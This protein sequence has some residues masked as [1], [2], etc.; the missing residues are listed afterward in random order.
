MATNQI[1]DFGKSKLKYIRIQLITTKFACD[2]GCLPNKE[3]KKVAWSK[4]GESQQ[5]YGINHLQGQ[6]DWRGF[7][8][9]VVAGANCQVIS[10]FLGLRELESKQ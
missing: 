8:F 10:S 2:I 1:I 6:S 4:I 7:P 3:L 5:K 9:W